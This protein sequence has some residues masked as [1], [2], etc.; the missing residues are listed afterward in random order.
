MAA[1]W[2]WR[3][4]Y[5]NLADK[6]HITEEWNGWMEG[7]EKKAEA[8]VKITQKEQSQWIKQIKLESG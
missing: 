3:S 7:K 2:N 6:E 5:V 4:N 1:C 8:C